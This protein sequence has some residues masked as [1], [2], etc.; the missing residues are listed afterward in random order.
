VRPVRFIS[1]ELDAF[2]T[3]DGDN[4][5]NRVWLAVRDWIRVESAVHVS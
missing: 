1:E 5:Y 3:E 4:E 2:E